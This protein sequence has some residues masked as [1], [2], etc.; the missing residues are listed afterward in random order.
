MDSSVRTNFVE[1]NCE[2]CYRD[3]HSG[4]AGGG[5]LMATADV[6]QG[7]ADDAED[8]ESDNEDA[9]SKNADGDTGSVEGDG[10]PDDGDFDGVDE[11]EPPTK[12]EAS[13]R[14]SPTKID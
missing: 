2:N 7:N 12:A 14:T 5:G 10:G 4:T 3:G 13:G 11:P 6:K 9:G 8:N 1:N